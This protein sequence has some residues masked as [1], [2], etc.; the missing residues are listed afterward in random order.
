MFGR[1]KD[2][3][4]KII[5]F[6]SAQDFIPIPVPARTLVPTWYK[7]TPRFIDGGKKPHAME[8]KSPD[9]TPMFEG[10]K[11]VKACV[12]YFEP[13]IN[14]YLALLWQDLE[15]IR[16]PQGPQWRW[17]AFPPV[18]DVRDGRGMELLPIPAGHR[19]DQFVWKTPYSVEVPP[20]YSI[21]ITHPI[22]RFDLP[23]TT[24]SGIHDADALLP[25]GHLPFYL[26]E[27][28][29]GI[30]PKGT[31]LFQIIPYKRDDWKSVDGGDEQR[32]KSYLR[33]WEG[34]SRFMGHYRD[35]NWKKKKF[36]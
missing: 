10:N 16:T 12:P 23:F 21:L 29:E 1:K 24:I 5:K 18:M 2:K 13:F 22:N 34:I 33:T 11:T 8:V 35:T 32:N 19:K 30:I 27:D 31:P 6:S 26:R 15:I 14:G 25:S 20:G 17:L 4:S 7:D 36:D 28:F 9:G 3:S